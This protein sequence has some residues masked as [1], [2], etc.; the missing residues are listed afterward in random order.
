MFV[1]PVNTL[2]FI[3]Q[4]PIMTLSECVIIGFCLKLLKHIFSAKVKDRSEIFA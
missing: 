4:S 1:K 3:S 2:S